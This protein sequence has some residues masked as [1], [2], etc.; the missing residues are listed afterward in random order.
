MRIAAVVIGGIVV[1]AAAGLLVLFLLQ[2]RF[3][4]PAPASRAPI[5]ATGFVRVT[6]HTADGLAL[7]AL[8]RPA[9]ARRTVIFF[10]G[11]GDSLAGALAATQAL[12]AAGYGVLLP[13]YRGYGGNQGRPSEAGLYDDARAATAF[14]RQNGVPRDQTVAIGNS[15]GSGPATQIATEEHLAGLIIVSGYTSL[16]AVAADAVRL[17][18]AALIRDRYDNAA[19]LAATNLPVLVLH[20]DND[21]VIPVAHGRALAAAARTRLA[22]FPGAGHGLAYWP[23]AGDAEVHW[24][25]ALPVDPVVAAADAVR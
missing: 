14:L 3:I 2:R 20:G 8:Y 17:P 13:E 11:N 10:H 4:Y 23:Q 22:E 15:L 9:R 1:I 6:L 19:K 24:L 12:A 21:R 25:D 5:T 16:P 7:T 18:V